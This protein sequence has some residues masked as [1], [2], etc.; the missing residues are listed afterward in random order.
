M[1]A[2][3]TRLSFSSQLAVFWALVAVMCALLG[4][5]VLFMA[6]ENEGPRI[7]AA[8]NRSLVGCQA[9]ASRY[10]LSIDNHNDPDPHA[11]LMHAV[12]DVVLAQM[13]DVEGG[14]WRNAGSGRGVFEAYAF[15][16]YQGSGIKRDVPDAET[17]LI[18]RALRAAASKQTAATEFVSNRQDAVIVAACPVP[19]RPALLAW[20]LTRSRPPLGAWGRTLLAALV[21]LLAVIVGIA[22][23][24]GVRLRRWRVHLARVETSVAQHV[25]D[26]AS[27]LT[28]Q[29]PVQPIAMTGEPELDR[30]VEAFNTHAARTAALQT[31]A[32]EL[33]S[34]LAQAERFSALGRLAAQMAHEI[35][36]PIGAMRLK[37]ENALAGD[38]TRKQRAL[39]TILEQIHRVESQLAGLLALTQPVRVEVQ[40]V[41][42][43][44]WLD[45]RVI[46]HRDAAENAHVTLAVIEPDGASMSTPAEA[47][48]DAAQLSRA[49][50]N[51]LLNA[52]RHAPPDGRVTVKAARVADML[53]IEVSDDGPGVQQ[54]DRERI[55]E[56]F[57]TGHAAGS[58][59]GLAVVRE[60]AAAHGGRAFY[61]ARQMGACFV[62]E[63]P[64]RTS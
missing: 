5:L 56:P 15:P 53:R 39:A 51:L 47:V 8:R 61:E 14:F 34:K 41:P 43:R 10:D 48:F 26:T 2:A 28:A 20:T 32:V 40:G 33:N 31:Q 19:H 55:F 44:A 62:I 25:G 36:N 45:E 63:I 60:I 9:V 27:P 35:R 46:L 4:G 52:L 22:I 50:D 1:S 38:E 6:R 49:L 7:D 42:L 12:L 54:A 30:I 37:A 3:S 21:A 13:P 57:V 11:D 24:L 58:G 59:L 29:P 17:P 16:T 64:W 23:A 18:L